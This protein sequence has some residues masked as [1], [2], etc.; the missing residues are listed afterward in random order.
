MRLFALL[1]GVA[2]LAASCASS[3]TNE[4]DGGNAS[5]GTAGTSG[6]AGTA[7][8]GGDGSSNG[9]SSDGGGSSNAEG[10]AAGGL[11][12]DP[13]V[14]RLRVSAAAPVARVTT[15]SA[16]YWMWPSAFEDDVSGTEDAMKALA[17][18]LLRVG[19]YNN[20]ANTPMAFDD[21][22]LDR[23]IAYAR[24]V[25][26]EPLLQVPLLADASGARPTAETAADMVSYANVTQ[27][28]GVRYFSI[29]NEPDL[30][31]TQGSLANG[32]D[33]AIPGYTPDQYC[34]TARDFVAAMKGVDPSIRIVGP[35][36]AWHYVA[37]NDWLTPIL[38]EC[39]DLFDIV[40]IHRYPFSS[41]L[42]TLERAE[43]DAASFETTI[44]GVR[45]LM[46]AAGQGDKPLALTEMNVAYDATT[47]DQTASPTT[48]GSALWLADAFGAASERDLFTT[49]VWDISDDPSYALGLLG[50]APAHVPRPPYYAYELYAEHFGPTRLHVTDVPPHV[51]AYATRN[52]ADDSTQIIA[53]NFGTAAVPLAVEVQDLASAPPPAPFT[54]PG[55]SVT[56]LE[57]PDR[58]SPSATTYGETEHRAGSG[59]ASLP[60]GLTAPVDL[61]APVLDVPCS[62]MSASCPSATLPSATVT[63]SGMTTTDGLVFG[64]APYRWVSYTYTVAGQ[65]APTLELGDDGASFSASGTFTPPLDNGTWQGV[66]FY[67]DSDHCADV[68]A[69]T[70]I[71]FDLSGDLGDC[72]LSFGASFSGD[73]TAT[74][75]PGRGSCAGTGSQCYP[76]LASVGAPSASTPTTVS[77]PFDSLTGGA[78]V[79]GFDPSTL[80]TIEWQLNAPANGACAASFTVANVEFY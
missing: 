45:E 39:G 69:Y 28:Y 8:S 18:A 31:A 4:S 72:T 33:P 3:T 44:D 30:Y 41:A 66:G 13:S 42:A 17:P 12:I 35:D 15:W 1:G 10:G 43:A 56:A 19:G 24:A 61:G 29:G 59:P 34:A 53:V 22:E 75:N 77:V 71:R 76:P 7:G 2:L 27:G 62:E 54:L 68:S 63:T 47:C 11:G 25:G 65:S 78:P 73:A 64:S 9:G 37:G 51:H 60:P 70:G 16:N 20:D 32:A 21:A 50:P 5:A 58:G 80:I 48:T 55:L 74:D 49:A 36:L 40:A 79:A 57:I 14:V 6:T 67:L 38:T 46:L 23:A 52:A 26:A